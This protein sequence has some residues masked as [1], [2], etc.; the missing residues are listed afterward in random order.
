MKIKQL[1]VHT[2]PVHELCGHHVLTKGPIV[3]QPNTAAK[4][5]KRT[6]DKKLVSQKI[7][8]VVREVRHQDEGED[9]KRFAPHSD[10]LNSS[11]RFLRLRHQHQ[12]IIKEKLRV[13]F[14]NLQVCRQQITQIIVLAGHD[15]RNKLRQNQRNTRSNHERLT[16]HDQSKSRPITK[17]M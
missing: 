13:R 14:L 6:K 10:I 7:P 4:M 9:R 17:R 1:S 15:L 8:A 2:R 3:D 11:T 5:P 12:M 16:S